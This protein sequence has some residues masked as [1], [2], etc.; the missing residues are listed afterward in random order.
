[1]TNAVAMTG[2]AAMARIG[3][4]LR[5]VALVVIIGQ[6]MVASTAQRVCAAWWTSV[7]A[8]PPVRQQLLDPPIQ[9]RG[10]L[11]QHVLQLG[12]GL[13]PIELGRLQLINRE[14]AGA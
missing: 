8:L 7:D 3:P 4:C 10:Q 9:L 11:C 12:S 2:T 14:H 5:V 1:M 6:R 13:V